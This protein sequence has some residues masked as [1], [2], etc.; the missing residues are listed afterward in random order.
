MIANVTIPVPLP[1]DV[2]SVAADPTFAD[3]PER[4]KVAC[5]VSDTPITTLAVALFVTPPIITEAVI[6]K[7]A[8][9]VTVVGVPEIVPVDVSKSNPAGRVPDIEYVAI[10]RRSAPKVVVIGVISTPT[11]SVVL[12]LDNVII[13]FVMKVDVVIDGPAPEEL[14][15][16]TAA[17]YSVPG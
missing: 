16:V 17:S 8:A 4:T 6:V 10:E 14:L 13:G 7:V 5:A 12:D 11:I 2:V 9:E 15:A 1:P 3:E